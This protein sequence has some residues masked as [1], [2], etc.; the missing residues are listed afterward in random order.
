MNREEGKEEI[1]EEKSLSCSLTFQNAIEID[2]SKLREMARES[3]T[4][5]ALS[6]ALSSSPSQGIS[7]DMADPLSSAS[8]V[9]RDL[10]VYDKP[11]AC[12]GPDSS[13][14]EGE[15]GGLPYNGHNDEPETEVEN[16]ED[17]SDENDS[18]MQYEQL[19]STECTQAN[20]DDEVGCW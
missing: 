9:G 2:F 17:N 18:T 12:D 10:S 13:D 7:D 19:G 20:S 11:S 3:T 5:E 6:E 15:D 16:S 14:D 4:E 8:V 1:N